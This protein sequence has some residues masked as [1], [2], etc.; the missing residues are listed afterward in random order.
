[1]RVT[2]LT[3]LLFLTAFLL[4]PSW[5]QAAKEPR[6]HTLGD[7]VL[8]LAVPQGH[9]W[10][11]KNSEIGFKLAPE[12]YSD[13]ISHLV[14][15]YAFSSS[16]S[17][18]KLYNNYCALFYVGPA[19]KKWE[20]A[21]FAEMKKHLLVGKNATDE[22]KTLAMEYMRALLHDGVGYKI[23]SSKSRKYYGYLKDATVISDDP[24]SVLLALRIKKKGEK[25]KYVTMS[26]SLVRNKLLGTLYYQVSPSGK[27]RERV[28]N[29]TQAW[30]EALINAN[31]G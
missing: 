13:L 17:L 18:S 14:S 27:E 25:T 26:L 7:T 24:E 3:L 16:G 11:N 12:R 21:D 1:M 9:K 2:G 15:V 19:E 31:R 22:E 30:R 8:E 6:S 4:S 29:L 5:L 23:S 28:K 10:V 20:P